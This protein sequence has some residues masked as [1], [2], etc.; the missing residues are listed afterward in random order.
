M[1]P[2]VTNFPLLY[3]SVTIL[4]KFLTEQV[5]IKLLCVRW[6]YIVTVKVLRIGSWKNGLKGAKLDREGVLFV[7]TLYLDR[8]C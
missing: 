5:K 6:E 7:D 3:L 4:L 8:S 2:S 1:D